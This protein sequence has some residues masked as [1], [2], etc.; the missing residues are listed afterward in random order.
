MGTVDNIFVLHGL[1]SHM[2]NNNKKLYCSF[3]DFSK[4]FDY[5]VTPNL[6]QISIRLGVI[7]KLLNVIR[8][9]YDCIKSRVKVSNTLSNELSCML[10]VRQGECLSPLLFSLYINDLEEMLLLNGYQGIE[11]Y[12]FKVF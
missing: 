4:A 11:I 6:W 8:S 9:M 5:V 10:E 12:M 2:I 1:I 3:I 7:G